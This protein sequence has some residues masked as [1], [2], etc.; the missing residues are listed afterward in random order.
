MLK[1]LLKKRLCRQG[2]TIRQAKSSKEAIELVE[3]QLPDLVLMDVQMPDID[4]FKTCRVLKQKKS[5][6]HILILLI[7][8]SDDESAIDKAFLS[9]AD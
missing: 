1:H 8:Q 4:T 3:E 9:G 7:T 2:D 5:F 6:Q